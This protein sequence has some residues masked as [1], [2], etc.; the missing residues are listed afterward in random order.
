M[1]T[2][3]FDVTPEELESSANRIQEKITEFT[4]AYNSIYT[5]TAD[6]RVT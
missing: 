6:R 4:K 3:V 2:T 5:A 1:A